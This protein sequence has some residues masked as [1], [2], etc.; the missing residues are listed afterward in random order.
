MVE[1]V[2]K[3]TEDTQLNQPKLSPSQTLDAE[4]IMLNVQRIMK[5]T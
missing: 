2:K 4:V 3:I 5:V 1:E